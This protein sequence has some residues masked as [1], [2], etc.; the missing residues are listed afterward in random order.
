MLVAK[1]KAPCLKFRIHPARLSSRFW[2]QD[3]IIVK[4][5]TKVIGLKPSV[6]LLKNFAV[7]MQQSVTHTEGYSDVSQK[8]YI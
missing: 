3:G 8:S 5:Q 1:I 7:G 6:V 4:L 2:V